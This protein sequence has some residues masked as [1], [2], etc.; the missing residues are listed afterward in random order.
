MIA[1][2]DTGVGMDKTTQE[3]AFNP[4]FTTKEVGKDT[5][6]GL[7]QVYGFVRQS[8]GHVKIYSEIGEGSSVKMIYLPRSI[9]DKEAAVAAESY[10]V[11]RWTGAETILVVEDDE[12]LREYAKE[13]LE[14]LGYHVV[15]A[16]DGAAALE[17]LAREQHVDLLLTDVVIPGGLNGRQLAD[18]AVGQ[19]PDLRVLYMTGYTRNAIVNQGRL[20]RGINLVSKP[21]TFEEL[22]AKVRERLDPGIDILCSRAGDAPRRARAF[23]ARSSGC[24]AGNR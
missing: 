5:G 24:R 23:A 9:G 15:T 2:N 20:D 14:E 21:F 10:D 8:A 19:R 12:A 6:L 3:R 1:V 16:S 22:A 7:S 17:I 4:F 18:K 11:S 13:I